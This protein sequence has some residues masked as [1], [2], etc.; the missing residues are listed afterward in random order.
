[1]GSRIVFS[2]NRDGNYDQYQLYVMNADGSNQHRIYYSDAISDYATWSPDGNHI[3]FA[4]DKEDG[5]TGNFEIFSIEPETVEPEKRLT[6]RRGYDIYPSYSPDGSRIAF[7]SNTDGN[8]EIYLMNADG[9][10]LIRVTRD[11]TTDAEPSWSPDG[12]KI[13]FTSTR[14]GNSA[15]YELAVP[16]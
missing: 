2:S 3:A 7:M 8:W 10:H 4:N 13:V 9:S 6:F 12:S 1:D 15:I 5:R 16:E 11:T 14:G